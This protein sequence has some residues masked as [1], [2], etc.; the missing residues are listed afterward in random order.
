MTSTHF[1]RR[2]YFVILFGCAVLYIAMTMLSP[3]NPNTYN[4]SSVKLNLLKL[5]VIIPVLLI[6]LAAFSGATG[7]RTYAASIR[8]SQ[9]GRA[10]AEISKGLLILAFGIVVTTLTGTLRQTMADHGH[11]M[12]FSIANNYIVLIIALLAFYSIFQGSQKLQ[13]IKGSEE[14]SKLTTTIIAVGILLFSSVYSYAVL[15]N[16][17]R[18]H[19][20]DPRIHNSYF[21]P[22]W[23]I[24][25]TIILPYILSW[26]W[27][28]LAAVN[29]WSYKSRVKAPIYSAALVNLVRGIVGLTFFSIFLQFVTAA[30]ASV[31]KLTLGKILVLVYVILIF[32]AVS[33]L[34][35]ASG[36][37][38]LSRIEEV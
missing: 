27:G 30:A 2:P 6:W 29:V 25:L 16:P 1:N 17:Y 4:L 36:A 37:K 5:T 35:I 10:L 24:I 14:S 21:L 15:H 11:A 23:L 18:N 20:T 13:A 38:K 3:N 33:Y 19:T 8:K 22:D 31:E 9:D 7:F 34:F 32:Y 28:V 26:I 12:L